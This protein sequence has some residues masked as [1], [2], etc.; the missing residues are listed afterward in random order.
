M[1][2]YLQQTRREF[3]GQYKYSVDCDK[4]KTDPTAL[5]VLDGSVR[6]KH[7]MIIN[8][9][10]KENSGKI[11]VKIGKTNEI[12]KQEYDVAKK[13]EKLEGFIKMHCLFSCYNNAN[14]SEPMNINNFEV[15]QSNHTSNVDVLIMPY[16]NKGQTINDY[17]ESGIEPAEYKKI[18]KQVITNL[19]NAFVKTG[20]VHKDLHFGNILIGENNDPIIMD[21]DTSEFNKIQGFFWADL[22]R[23]FGNVTE[24]SYPS[25]NKSY[26]ISGISGIQI[27]L[28]T[29][30]FI[31]S[32]DEFFH[33]NVNEL[34]SILEASNVSVLDNTKK[35]TQ[36]VYNPDIFG[37]KN[38]TR[39]KTPKNKF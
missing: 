17:L 33:K 9:V 14:F 8:A 19:Y 26:I 15:C 32:S 3:K 30:M 18:L 29:I 11:V 37:G 36:M 7:T 25:N 31:T 10:V 28:N 23:L 35:P 13:L 21:F 24:K 1:S 4:I 22:Q 2:K 27:L 16:I 6:V 39:K 12:V 20:F 38:K 34:L 5:Q